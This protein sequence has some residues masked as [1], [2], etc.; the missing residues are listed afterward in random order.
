MKGAWKGC[1]MTEPMDWSDVGEAAAWLAARTG[2][3]WTPRRLLDATLRASVLPMDDGE[4]VARVPLTLLSAP[5]PV[6]MKH[7]ERSLQMLEWP[8]P[9]EPARIIKRP[10]KPPR[11]KCVRLQYTQVRDLISA[12]WCEV[13][14]AWHV[15]ATH[16]DEDF[17]PAYDEA[18]APYIVKAEA[19]GF[20]REDL[21]TL[22]GY[23][24]RM[25]PVQAA[26][27]ARP[28]TASEPG[29][30]SGSLPLT[31]GDIAF[32]FD[33]IR[34][35]E[36][37]WKKPLGDK[38]KWLAACVAIPGQR[39]V[40][41]TRWNPVQIAAALVKDGH[42]K[43]NSVRARFQTKPPLAPWLDAWKTY[44]AEYLDTP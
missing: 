4:F 8:D 1:A 16:S 2:E 10:D 36:Q 21:L 33:G 17:I 5:P 13:H 15:P 30:V 3:G 44:E 37:E 40:S 29:V 22:A 41:E 43:A 23:I 32:S 9:D 27:E 24:E 19:C 38:P 6:G 25:R 18:T 31:T 42:S 28:A 35:S 12:G 34:W 26:P 14:R 39:G 7:C 11:I 20:W